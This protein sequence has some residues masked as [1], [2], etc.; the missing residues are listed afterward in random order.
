MP[1][2]PSPI[3]NAFSLYYDLMSLALEEAKKASLSGE[4]PVGSALLTWEGKVYSN[5]NRMVERDDPL[6][7][8]EQLV[9]EEAR[10]QS[11]T[12]KLEGAILAVTLEPCPMCSGAMMICRIG[13]LVYGVRDPRMG[14]VNS[15][16]EVFGNPSLNHHPIIV[17]GILEDQAK[18]MMRRFFRRRRSHAFS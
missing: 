17:S 3:K 14:G 2:S 7:H 11:L 18:A 6:A 13:T 9:I 5:H 12:G 15:V 1:S 10:K 4:I 8:A 16:F